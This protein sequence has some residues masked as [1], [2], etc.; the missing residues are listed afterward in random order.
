[1]PR[2]TEAGAVYLAFDTSGAYGSVAVGRVDTGPVPEIL[3]RELIE[4]RMEQAARLVPAID[5]ALSRAGVD[6]TALAGLV[7]GEGPGSFTGVRVAAATAKGL[8]HALGLPLLAVSSLAAAALAHDAG[9]VRYVLFDARADRVY[10]A[11]YGVGSVGV[12]ELVP[13]HAGTLRD[14]LAGDVPAG[15][16]FVGDGAC[17]H[18][19][20]IEGAG[21]AVDAGAGARSHAEGLLAYVALQGDAATAVD[22]RSWEPRYVRASSAEPQWS[23]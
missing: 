8:A 14:V 17:R 23:A 13:P 7:V 19:G 9:P 5:T 10:G 22:A 18:G 1:M 2:R 21:Y 20:A 11:C 6:R 4:E 12:R 16:V 15:A 3:S